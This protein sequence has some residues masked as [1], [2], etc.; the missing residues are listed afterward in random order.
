MDELL[1]S[2]QMRPHFVRDDHVCLLA[3][4]ASLVLVGRVNLLCSLHV[5]RGLLTRRSTD[6]AH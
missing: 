1:A 2:P 4:I 3:A 5:S 6:L